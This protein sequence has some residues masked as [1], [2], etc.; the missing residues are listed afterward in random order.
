MHLYAKSFLCHVAAA[1]H[2]ANRGS[3]LL[4]GSCYRVHLDEY[5][6]ARML[7]QYTQTRIFLVHTQT[8]II[9]HNTQSRIFIIAPGTP[10]ADPTTG[11]IR[12]PDAAAISRAAWTSPDRYPGGY[13]VRTCERAFAD[14]LSAGSG[15]RRRVPGG[16]ELK[17]ARQAFFR[18]ASGSP[19]KQAP[20]PASPVRPAAR[21]GRGRRRLHTKQARFAALPSPFRAE[22][23]LK[24]RCFSSVFLWKPNRHGLFR[25]FYTFSYTYAENYKK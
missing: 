6:Q 9:R 10:R 16:L 24:S 1:P 20:E 17:D 15:D 18:R 2:P 5:T 13:N 23:Q 22:N 12:V 11:R 4:G 3:H 21:D 7:C 8:R 25:Y 14:V 19:P